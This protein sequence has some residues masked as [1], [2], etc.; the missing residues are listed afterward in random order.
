MEDNI[1]IGYFA[2]KK[3][4]SYSN[5]RIWIE[6][7]GSRKI[8]YK[9][10]KEHEEEQEDEEDEEEVHSCI[11]G[12]AVLVPSGP[13]V[14]VWWSRVHCSTFPDASL[15]VRVRRLDLPKNGKCDVPLFA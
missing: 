5:I 9:L 12:I 4:I 6:L 2:F 13:P 8:N 10:E 3:N 1:T 15:Q 14:C 11:S 7:E